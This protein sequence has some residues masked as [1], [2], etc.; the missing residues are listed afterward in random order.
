M[1]FFPSLKKENFKA[2]PYTFAKGMEGP[3]R[4]TVFSYLRKANLKYALCNV[5]TDCLRTSLASSF[6][7]LLYPHHAAMAY[8][9]HAAITYPF[10]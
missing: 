3:Q 5:G 6:L 2:F 4:P 7:S 1:Q 9:H 10:P 8:P